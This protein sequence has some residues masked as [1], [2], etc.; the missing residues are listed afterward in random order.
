VFL[1]AYAAQDYEMTRWPLMP[2][3]PRGKRDN[4]I[5]IM[6]R[7]YQRFDDRANQGMQKIV[8]TPGSTETISLVQRLILHMKMH[9]TARHMLSGSPVSAN[10]NA[11]V[12]VVQEG[13]VVI[14][15]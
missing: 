10:S 3:R 2:Y 7:R 4:I 15:P 12:G 8:D 9:T 6:N 5:G 13:Q 11:N 1:G 14:A